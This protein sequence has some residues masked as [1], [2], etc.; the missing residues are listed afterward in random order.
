EREHD[1]TFELD[2]PPRFVL[3]DP[4]FQVLADFHVDQPASA[5]VAQLRYALEPAARAEA[6]RALAGFVDQPALL[7]GLRT[8]LDVE[9]SPDV[10]REIIRTAALLPNDEA[11]E[12]L[13]LAA[14]RDDRA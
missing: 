3:P 5:W 1:F 6:A 7:V 12:Q 10:R 13:L 8:A 11:K 2:M 4:D 14:T 9:Q